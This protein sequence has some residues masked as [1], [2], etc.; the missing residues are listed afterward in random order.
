MSN[1]KMVGGEV[2]KCRKGGCETQWVS[3]SS[4]NQ[5]I[6]YL[7]PKYHLDCVDLEFVV[8][9]WMCPACAPS[10]RPAKKRKI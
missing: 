5:Q 2:I 1:D 6:T 10:K 4:K 7:S 8:A 3:E 9:G